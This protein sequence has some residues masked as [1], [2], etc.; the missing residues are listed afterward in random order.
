MSRGICPNCGYEAKTP[1]DPLLAEEDGRG[2]CPACGI[3]VSKFTRSREAQKREPPFL[4]KKQENLPETRSSATPFHL[5]RPSTLVFLLV[6]A[7]LLVAHYFYRRSSTPPEPNVDRKPAAAAEILLSSEGG[8]Q[9]TKQG[10]KILPGETKS[11]VLTTYLNFLHQ[12]SYFPLTLESMDKIDNK[13]E[14]EGVQ[15]DIRHKQISPI[16]VPLWE[17]YRDKDDLWIPAGYGRIYS[18][19]NNYGI[20]EK[21]KNMLFAQSP[22]ALVKNPEKTSVKISPSDSNYRKTSYTFYRLEYELSI[23]VPSG[24]AF[25]AQELTATTRSGVTVPQSSREKNVC[26]R[27]FLQWDNDSRAQALMPQMNQNLGGQGPWRATKV[28][29]SGSLMHC[30]EM[31][32]VTRTSGLLLTPGEDEPENSSYCEITMP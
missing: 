28:S 30:I 31:K 17:Q 13:W 7:G 10:L 15:V 1:D 26:I 12:E 6:V 2:E 23:Y 14:A 4:P 3:I 20:I 21:G 24:P 8:A 18:Q 22:S 25:E 11:V 27:T 32:Q 29:L 9:E 16:T 19:G 5:P